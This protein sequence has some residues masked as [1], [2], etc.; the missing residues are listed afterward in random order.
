MPC[1]FEM[2]YVCGTQPHSA[3]PKWYVL[4][5]TQFTFAERLAYCH[6]DVVRDVSVNNNTLRRAIQNSESG[7][8]PFI[9]HGVW[10]TIGNTHRLNE[11]NTAD[12]YMIS[13][14]AYL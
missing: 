1:D 7:Q 11:K 2:V 6:T 13:D 4:Q 10:Q 12:I 3:S 5:N 14:F 8:A 9:L